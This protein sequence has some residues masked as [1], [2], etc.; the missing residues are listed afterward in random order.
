MDNVVVTQADRDAAADLTNGQF[1]DTPQ[2]RL[3]AQGGFDDHP[4]VQAFARHRIAAEQAIV[5]WLLGPCVPDHS[6]EGGCPFD[7]AARMIQAG[8]HRT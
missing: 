8:E 1:R 5:D 4:A 2:Y 3:I 6:D 7:K